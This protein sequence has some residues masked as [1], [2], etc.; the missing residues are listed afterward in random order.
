MGTVTELP[1]RVA[2]FTKVEWLRVA[3]QIK[4][5]LTDAEYDRMWDRYR[6]DFAEHVREMNRG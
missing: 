2:G 6:D 3:R 4:P 1:L 5:D